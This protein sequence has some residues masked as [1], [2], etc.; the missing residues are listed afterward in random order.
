[1]I[2][3]L[4]PY[5]F[6]L[7]RCGIFYLLILILTGCGQVPSVKETRILMDTFCEISCYGDS[8]DKS[9]AAIGAAFKEM[10]RIE[11]VFSK[12]NKNSEVSNINRL[13]GLEKVAA[14]E[15]VFKLTEKSV[16]YS[17]ISDGAF[18]ITVAPLM[19]IWGFVRRHKSIPD[20]ETIENA[21]EGVGYKNIELDPKK[22]SVKFLNKKTKID[23][24]GIAK[25]YAVDRAKDV[26][27]SRGIKNGLVNLGGNIFALG[28][29][30]GNKAW[31]IGVEDPRNKGKLLRSFELTNR[32]I[33][34]SGNYE[35]FFE[36]GGKRYSH[37][38][39]PLT[40][41]PCQGIISVTVAADS[42]EQADGLS[43]AIFVMGEEKGL[44]LAKSI[45]GI[46][47]LIL[48]ED[49]KIISYP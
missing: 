2:F 35:R 18:D 46:K 4:R 34:T 12:F 14:S 32:A 43:T 8:K 30:P 23:F 26:L 40:G 7:K 37:I 17:R 13:A 5:L 21:L 10:E 20:K 6:A 25:G 44:N 24:G 49:G 15:E 19:E 27:V 29:A 38:I 31:K 36:I 16:Y 28:S 47:V 9:I 1:M 39:N 42:A 48:K 33:S 11:K 41:E 3:K 22:L 45:K